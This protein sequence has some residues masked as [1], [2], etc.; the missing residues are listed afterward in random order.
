MR[1]LEKLLATMFMKACMPNL[2]HKPS[3]RHYE[4]DVVAS[5]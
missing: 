1:T 2:W 5:H 4:D 3:S